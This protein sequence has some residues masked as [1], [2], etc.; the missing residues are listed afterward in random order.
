M[1]LTEV[2]TVGSHLVALFREQ[3]L[4]AIRVEDTVLHSELSRFEYAHQAIGRSGGSEGSVQRLVVSGNGHHVDE[5]VGVVVSGLVHHSLTGLDFTGS[6]LEDD[7]AGSRVLTNYVVEAVVGLHLNSEGKR[8]DLEARLALEFVNHTVSNHVVEFVFVHCLEREGRVVGTLGSVPSHDVGAHRV[9]IG[10]SVD[11]AVG[12]LAVTYDE[13]ECTGV[14]GI[15]NTDSLRRFALAHGS[16]VLRGVTIE[17]ETRVEVL[18]GVAILHFLHLPVVFEVRL[19]VGGFLVSSFCTYHLGINGFGTFEVDGPIA[20]ARR[21]LGSNHLA[22]VALVGRFALDHVDAIGRLEERV[23]HF[24]ERGV[25]LSHHVVNFSDIGLASSLNA[26]ELRLHGFNSSRERC[27]SAGLVVAETTGEFARCLFGSL[28]DFLC[29]IDEFGHTGRIGIVGTELV[30]HF[31][32]SL[33]RGIRCL[34]VFEFSTSGRDGVFQCRHVCFG[35]RSDGRSHLVEGAFVDA[36][37]R[38]VEELVAGCHGVVTAV[39]QHFHAV[40]LVSLG[41]LEV[42][43]TDSVVDLRCVVELERIRIGEGADGQRIPTVFLPSVVVDHFRTVSVGRGRLRHFELRSI[44]RSP[45]SN[46]NGSTVVEGRFA[47]ETLHP[48]EEEFVLCIV[49]RELEVVVLQ[50][51]VVTTVPRSVEVGVGLVVE[52]HSEFVFGTRTFLGVGHRASELVGA[53]YETIHSFHLAGGS[54]FDLVAGIVHGHVAITL[55]ETRLRLVDEALELGVAAGLLHELAQLSD[56]RFADGAHV[57]R[58]TVG[59]PVPRHDVGQRA[60]GVNTGEFSRRL[61]QVGRIEAEVAGD[62]G[63]RLNVVG[64]HGSFRYRNRIVEGS[65][66]TDVVAGFEV[67]EIE[68]T[69]LLGG[70]HFPHHFAGI[71]REGVAFVVVHTVILAKRPTERAVAGIHG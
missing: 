51:S 43:C 42:S 39:G 58:R 13:V 31:L 3:H 16:T 57:P 60:F 23:A 2:T 47:V 62:L 33:D 35:N 27:L 46:T 44:V 9:R 14:V 55:I 19:A 38:T 67:A 64:V 41:R 28:H 65:S 8:H 17:I 1:E 12:R 56:F 30:E 68:L 6:L 32:Q 45:E 22:V 34:F 66:R 7:V 21:A 40:V 49:K 71:V 50:P 26:G 36:E 48:L 63:V 59:R 20:V 53:L 5:V 54:G 11:V 29:L 61:G 37:F 25:E 18:E 52:Q 24:R 10:L 4:R 69:F 70:Y 15:F